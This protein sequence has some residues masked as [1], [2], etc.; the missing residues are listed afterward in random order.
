MQYTWFES[1]DH[2][3]CLISRGKTIRLRE[4]KAVHRTPFKRQPPHYKYKAEWNKRYDR[5]TEE[6]IEDAG[7]MDAG[8]PFCIWDT[9]KRNNSFHHYPMITH[10]LP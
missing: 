4:L 10:L 1:Y 5:V 6:M 3:I 2:R 7:E 8:Y 9:L